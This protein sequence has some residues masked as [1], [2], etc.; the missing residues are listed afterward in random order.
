VD[1][2]HAETLARLFNLVYNSAVLYG[3]THQT[4]MDSSVPFYNFL[5]KLIKG[6]TLISILAERDSV[7]IENY[8]VDKIINA[9][10]LI[11][12]F[13]K[14]GLQSITFSS[15]VS[16][17]GVRAFLQILSDMQTYPTAELM[18][19]GLVLQNAKGIR[20]NYVVYRK[21]TADE[22]IVNKDMVTSPAASA[23]RDH[24]GA[25]AH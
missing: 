13:K 4:T 3:G 8:C 10:R 15:E 9:R 17:E 22:A 14:A 24:V 5:A 18:K 6:D 16:L 20:L 25:G 7:Y 21:M 1:Q 23:V 19:K 11:M 2:R 12:H